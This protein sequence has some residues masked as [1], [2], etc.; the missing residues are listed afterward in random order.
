[1]HLYLVRHAT[2]E[3]RDA[4]WDDA[5]RPLT[6]E[7]VERFDRV[8]K[9]LRALRVELDA[10]LHS[11][12]RRAVETAHRLTP[13]MVQGQRRE[14]DALAAPPGEGLLEAIAGQRAA[15]VGHEPWMGELLAWLVAGDRFLGPSFMFKKGGVAWLEGEPLPGR[16]TL[17]ALWTPRSLREAA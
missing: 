12:W 3:A 15:L 16:C 8:V 17:R 7:G 5:E 10:V 14:T 13:L 11:P 2:A 9:G 6:L 4:G 1:M